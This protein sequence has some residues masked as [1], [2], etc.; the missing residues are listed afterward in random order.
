MHNIK[1]CNTPDNSGATTAPVLLSPP[2]T[3]TGTPSA[4]PC[5]PR[6]SACRRPPRTQKALQ[7][8]IHPIP[9]VL[10]LPYCTLLKTPS[11]APYEH[12]SCTHAMHTTGIASNHPT[13]LAPGASPPA[14]PL[15]PHTSTEILSAAP[16]R[17]RR[18]ACRRPPPP[19]SC[20]PCL[21][22][23]PSVPDLVSQPPAAAAVTT[24]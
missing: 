10:P 9:P 2:H 3:S 17:P 19:A 13:K 7:G 1:H 5:T 22:A 15:P 12:K 21:K 24:R 4:A 14:L 8:T 20:Q 6:R 16:C 23:T 18:S 11:A